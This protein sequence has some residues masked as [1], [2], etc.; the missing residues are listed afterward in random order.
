MSKYKEGDY[1]KFIGYSEEVADDSKVFEE[2]KVYQVAAVSEDGTSLE[3]LVA[4]PDFDKSIDVSESNPKKVLAELYINEVE[5]SQE[6]QPTAKT[7][8]VVTT[9]AATHVKQEVVVEKPAP[10]T[11]KLKKQIAAEEQLTRLGL[12]P[13]EDAPEVAP[14]AQVLEAMDA[15]QVLEALGEADMEEVLEVVEAIGESKSAA[16]RRAAQKKVTA[17]DAL[18][19]STA[20]V[21]KET[22]EP[23]EEDEDIPLPEGAESPKILAMVKD[24][25]DGEL[26]DLAVELDHTSV[27]V[28]GELAG[29]LYH[30]KKTKAY[31]TL[32]VKY[33]KKGGFLA[34]IKDYLKTDYRKAMYLVSSYVNGTRHL[35]DFMEQMNEIGWTKMAK[36]TDVMTDAN[37]QELIALAKEKSVSELSAVISESFRAVGEDTRDKRKKITFK[38]RLWEDQATAV[39]AAIQDAGKMFG[40]KDLSDVFERIVMEWAVDHPS[41]SLTEEDLTTMSKGIVA[42]GVSDLNVNSVSA[43]M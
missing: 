33:A 35:P 27:S 36:I 15:P 1:V 2:G 39:N 37:A 32:G 5:P 19:P 22:D 30:V 20:P 18:P 8:K 4:N 29:I 43:S 28:V 11:H 6:V 41:Q 17:V 9:S 34:Y 14:I 24:A 12:L 21:E 23:D 42:N 40:Y 16:K 7:R 31:R 10:R 25:T 38:F 3:I 26:L 13:G